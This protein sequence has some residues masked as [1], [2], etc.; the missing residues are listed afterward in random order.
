MLVNRSIPRCAVIPELAYPDVSEAAD[1]LCNTFGF[2][3]RVL[4]GN[5]RA[6]L[7]VGDGAIVVTEQRG[8][9]KQGSAASAARSTQLDHSVMVRLD[10]VNSHYER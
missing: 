1:W 5:H 8:E 7:N 4:T 3:L 6:Q 9:Q 2:T 10:D